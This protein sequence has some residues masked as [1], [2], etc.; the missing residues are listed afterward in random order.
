MG[1]VGVEGLVK[2]EG[3]GVIVDGGVDG[4][5]GR[6]YVFVLEAGEEFLD[7]ADALSAAGWVAKGVVVEVFHVEGVFETFPFCLS[8]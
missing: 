4:G 8:E 6:G 7:V 2:G 3:G 1:E 5:V